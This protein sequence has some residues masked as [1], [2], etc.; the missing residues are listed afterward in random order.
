MGALSMTFDS[1]SKTSA[2]DV[3]PV[4]PHKVRIAAHGKE[5]KILTKIYDE[6]INIVV[7]QRVLSESLK[8][9][10]NSFLKTQSSFHMAMTV[11]PQNVLSSVKSSIGDPNLVELCENISELVDMFCC[12][13]D[14][15]Y[16]GLRLTVLDRAMCPKFHV[17]RVPCRLVTTYQGLATEWLPHH[18]VN[19][20]KLGAG[21]CGQPDNK[22]GLFKRQ[23]DVQQI[24]CGDVAI[25]KGELWEGNENAGLVHRSPTLSI[26]ENRLLL[27]L[28]CCD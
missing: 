16:A 18:M 5:P 13:L 3:P 19:R 27:T 8:T 17:D 12:L 11:T 6:K 24:D 14:L 25:L 26:G 7:W 28:D 9:V 15:K 4:N 22:S 2:L 21:S 10:I 23:Q 20:E 1:S